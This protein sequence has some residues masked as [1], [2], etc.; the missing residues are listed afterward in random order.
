M[1][2]K[3]LDKNDYIDL[4]TCI[5]KNFTLTQDDYDDFLV[6]NKFCFNDLHIGHKSKYEAIDFYYAIKAQGGKITSK[7]L[8]NGFIEQ[9]IISLKMGKYNGEKIENILMNLKK[10]KPDGKEESLSLSECLHILE[11]INSNEQKL[12]HHGHTLPLW[13]S[14]LVGPLSNKEKEICRDICQNYS[15]NLFTREDF[16]KEID[17]RIF[18]D[19]MTNEDSYI[20][21][22]VELLKK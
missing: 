20:A 5:E 3:K 22:I 6:Q 14:N 1:S 12:I 7:N 19:D 18:R 11:R 8:N 4:H 9:F 21:E 2:S 16:I 15:H 10:T 13:D 17:K